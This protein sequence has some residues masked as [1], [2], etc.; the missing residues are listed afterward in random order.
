MEACESGQKLLTGFMINGAGTMAIQSGS[1][2][3]L[4]HRDARLQA[5]S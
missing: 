5:T 4:K 3:A 1:L 2:Q